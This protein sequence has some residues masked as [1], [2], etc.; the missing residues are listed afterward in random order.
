MRPR[1]PDLAALSDT[2]LLFE[3]IRAGRTSTWATA[4]GPVMALLLFL[5]AAVV[6]FVW[7][8]TWKWL[9]AGSVA[10]L[11]LDKMLERLKARWHRAGPHLAEFLR[12]HGAG[13]L[14]SAPRSA[15]RQPCV[16]VLSVTTLP[17]GGADSAWIVL[18]N[19]CAPSGKL[20]HTSTSFGAHERDTAI[21]TDSPLPLAG[22]EQIYS[23]LATISSV[24]DGNGRFPV[25]DGSPFDLEVHG[26]G[27]R[28]PLRIV[29]NLAASDHA[30]YA[31]CR[32]A[33]AIL[34]VIEAAHPRPR[35]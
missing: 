22:A 33:S 29:G 20:V 31:G 23:V 18:N 9:M 4:S 1:T 21:V 5:S 14:A 10:V 12:R 30:S 11:L 24:S 26:V 8:G 19:E 34:A 17:H 16:L 25:R 13:E 35:L 3:S 15:D 28:V 6:P 2:E 27:K 7:E 32:L